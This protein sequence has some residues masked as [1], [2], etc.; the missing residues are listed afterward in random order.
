MDIL[1]TILLGALEGFTEF[2][3]VSSTGHLILAERVLGLEPTAFLLSFTIIIQLGAIAAV[4]LLYFKTLTRSW[5]VIWHLAAAFMPAAVAGL[6]LY[7]AI[8]GW[9]SRPDIV[10]WALMLG[11]AVMIVLE[12]WVLPRHVPRENAVRMTY[13]TALLI[14]AFQALALV[15]GVSRSAATIIGG[16]VAGLSRSEAVKFSF[17]LALPTMTAATGLDLYQ[18]AHLFSAGQLW[19]LVLGAAVACLTA[20]AAMRWLLRY[21]E[22]HDLTIFGAYRIALAAVFWLLVL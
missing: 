8:K 10:L 11:G 17:L 6:V 15:P 9:L 3:P 19:L 13:R 4:A 21:L 7:P 12:R 5:D 16:L 14:G 20:I 1:T 2:V 22:R 18:N